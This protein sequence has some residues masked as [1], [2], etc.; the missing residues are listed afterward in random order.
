VINAAV[1]VAAVEE[2]GYA[3]AGEDDIGSDSSS[4]HHNRLILAEAEAPAMKE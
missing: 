4:T 1:P 2:D 3:H